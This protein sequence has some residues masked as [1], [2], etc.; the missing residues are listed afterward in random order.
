M[1]QAAASLPRSADLLWIDLDYNGEGTLENGGIPLTIS[2]Q[3][4]IR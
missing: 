2:K 1:I 4:A 3:F